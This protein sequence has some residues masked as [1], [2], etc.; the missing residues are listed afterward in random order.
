[1]NEE[2][3]SSNEE[4]ETMNDELRYRTTE[5]NEIN[6]FLDTILTAV[7]LAVAAARSSS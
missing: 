1:M 2:L 6:V 7:G 4:L 3:Q 5:L